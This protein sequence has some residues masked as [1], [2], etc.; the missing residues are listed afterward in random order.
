MFRVKVFLILEEKSEQSIINEE[1]F[2][3]LKKG[4][5]QFSCV[6]K[7]NVVVVQLIC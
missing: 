2:I 6:N 7:K 1:N 3:C 5:E 4:R